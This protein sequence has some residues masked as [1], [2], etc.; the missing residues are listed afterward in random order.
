MNTVVAVAARIAA[1]DG[2]VRAELGVL[3]AMAGLLVVGALLVPQYRRRTAAR[4]YDR[5][6]S[7]VMRA[8]SAPE[9]CPLHPR[10]YAVQAPRPAHGRFSTGPATPPLHVAGP[11]VSHTSHRRSA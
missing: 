7:A 6:V 5:A 2:A 1:A 3:A 4:S 9:H 10:P 11:V 8:T